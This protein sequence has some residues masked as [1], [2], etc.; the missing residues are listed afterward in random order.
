M[1][2]AVSAAYFGRVDRLFVALGVQQWGSFIPDTNA[3]Q[4]HP[5]AELGD[6]DLLNAAAIQTILNGGTVYAMPP[7]QVPDEAPL[8]AIFRY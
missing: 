6:E 2:E 5:D 7:E 8:A 3:V 4:V 1:K